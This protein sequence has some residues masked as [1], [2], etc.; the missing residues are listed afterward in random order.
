MF[1]S[2][3]MCCV[4]SACIVFFAVV[5]TPASAL[6]II[7]QHITGELVDPGRQDIQVA[8]DNHRFSADRIGRAAFDVDAD[9]SKGPVTGKAASITLRVSPDVLNEG[10][11][12]TTI[13][14]TA[15][16]TTTFADAQVLPITV[17]GSGVAN[18]VDF[19]DVPGFDLTLAAQQTTTSGTFTLTPIDDQENEN[20]E[21]ITVSSTHTGVSNTTEI[22]LY[23]NDAATFP[24]TLSVAPTSVSEGDGSTTITVTVT[25]TTFFQYDHRIPITVRG[26]GVANAVDFT[27]VPAF[28]IVLSGRQT[29]TFGT[30]TL[31][32]IDDQVSE[33][34]ETITVSSPYFLVS[35]SNTPTITLSDNDGPI[36]LSVSPDVLNERDGST[37]ITVTATSTTTYAVAQVLPI[38]VRGTGGRDAV[39]FNAVPTFNITL[40]AN[41]T[42][43]SG[44]FT[45]TPID[46]QEFEKTE[47][48]AVSSTHTGVSSTATI[49]LYDDDAATF[50]ITLSVA[51]TSVNEGDGSTT[52]TVTATSTTTFTGAQVLP[53]TVTG[54]GVANAVDFSVVPG[55]DLTLAG[56]QTT[57]N[58]TFTLTP[59]DDLEGEQDET[60]TVGSPHYLVSNTA[61]T[62]TLYDNDGGA[63][64]ITLSVNPTSVS[65]G[66]GSTTI[67]V[68]ATTTT[69]FTSAQVLPITVTGSGVA[70]AVDFSDVPGF[71]L[72]MGANQTVA[73]AT[74]T[75]L[76][77]DDQDDEQDEIITVS[78]THSLVSNTATITLHDDDVWSPIT[79]SVDPAFINEA[80]GSTVITIVAISTAAFTDAQVLPIT[81]AGSGIEE[82]VDFADVSE[83]DLTLEVNQTAGDATFTLTPTDD[84]VDELD[85]TITVSSTSTL[86]FGSATILLTDDDDAPSGISLSV[87]PMSVNE[88]DGDT[89]ITV[90]GTPTGGTAYGVAQSLDLKVEGSGMTGVVGFSPVSGVTLPIATGAVSGST[91]FVLSPID[92]PDINADETIT[93]S[94]TN[95]LVSDS[96][97]MNLYDGGG[98]PVRLRVAPMTVRE[99]DGPT[100]VTVTATSTTTFMDAQVLPVTVGGSGIV[101]AVD[102]TNVPGFDLTLPA[103]E[104]TVDGTFTLTPIDD[105]V[106][107][108]DERLFISS[109]HMQVGSFGLLTLQD[110]DD[111]PDG[112][113]LSVSPDDIR[114]NDGATTITLTATVSGMTRYASE[115]VMNVT[116]TDTG[117]MGAVDF[118]PVPEFSLSVVAEA[119]SGTASFVL[120]PENDEVGE[121]DETIT[122]SSDSTFVLSDAMLI[123]RDDDGGRTGRDTDAEGA[124]FSVGAPYPNPA[125][126]TITF[127]LSTPE[128]AEWTRLRL[129]NVLGQEVA[130]PYEGTLRAGSHTVR[131]DG[132]HLPAGVYVYVFESHDTRV[133][134]QLIIS[135]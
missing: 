32:P 128:A 53:I 49:T 35:N 47:H 116:M 93:I 82:A 94:S 14:V 8:E 97:M 120:T 10:D 70:N 61:A 73:N 98:A 43:A 126:G 57:T 38:T 62:I 72:T 29:T 50:P 118:A 6:A 34:D 5:V 13:T 90:T 41:Q 130:V 1:I 81:V 105:I 31:T 95:P 4:R 58:G 27:N 99:G 84:L 63:F 54:S 16:S 103:N 104:T 78:S 125:S 107:E 102:F 115:K 92:D 37:T 28:R 76:P 83:F 15:T 24:F 66:D 7:Q 55:F 60:I 129:Y 3:P 106:D 39:D 124:E 20:T 69:V 127:V 132:S 89:T 33:Q 108:M 119:S 67:T 134:G 135:Q 74:F 87:H 11:G 9:Q 26:S 17:A 101:E 59:I 68:T 113:T 112:I 30:F 75:L 51:P 52:I 64:P 123:I 48:V 100:T 65:E 114:E 18:R 45:L 23:D 122:L 117:V 121:A 42:T 109:S 111:A 36:T 88:R 12:S 71:N 80:D 77:I 96:A 22:T 110:D 21:I 19:S 44:T 25:S 46:D 56:Q 86:V 133:T 79:L 2:S 131:Y 91:T 40:A 85:E